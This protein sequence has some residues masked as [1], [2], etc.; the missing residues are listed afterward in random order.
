MRY[1]LKHMT[2]LAVIVGLSVCMISDVYP[3][4]VRVEVE[5][6][7]QKTV[8]GSTIQLTITVHG[9]NNIGP[10]RLP[11]IEGFEVRYVGPS[12]QVSI[13]NGRQ[14]SSKSFIL[15]PSESKGSG[16]VVG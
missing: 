2:I 8:L 4:D 1:M 16:G 6:S 10:M 14:T 12:T 9:N 11:A 5:V 15:K 3:Q 13:Y 7:S